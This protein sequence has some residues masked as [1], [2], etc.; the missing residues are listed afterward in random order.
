MMKKIILI[1]LTFFVMNQLAFGQAKDEPQAPFGLR[2]GMTIDEVRKLNLKKFDEYQ[3]KLVHT[4]R[5]KSVPIEPK[6]DGEYFLD[7]FPLNRGLRSISFDISDSGKNYDNLK[8]KFNLIA[9][10]LNNKYGKPVLDEQNNHELVK[11]YEYNQM[12]IKLRLN[13]GERTPYV[14]WVSYEYY[15]TELL[16]K[17]EPILKKLAEKYDNPF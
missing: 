2:W 9:S 11:D 3:D 10:S 5:T 12:A 13:K 15:P 4:I 14:L 7:F 17:D 1:I 6:Y 16:T 8:E